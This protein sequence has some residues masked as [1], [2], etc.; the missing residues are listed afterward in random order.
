MIG[1]R[2]IQSFPEAFCS[3]P[4]G[5][6]FWKSKNE[7]RGSRLIAVYNLSDDA[8]LIVNQEKFLNKFYKT[9]STF[10]RYGQRL[11]RLSLIKSL[12]KLWVNKVIEPC[13]ACGVLEP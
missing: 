6:A 11:W 12:I 3:A 9:E 5:A 13:K 7:Q 2:P 1:C 4:V 8:R 10:R